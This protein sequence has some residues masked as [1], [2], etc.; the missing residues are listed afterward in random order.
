[1]VD[2]VSY[3]IIVFGLDQISRKDSSENKQNNLSQSDIEGLEL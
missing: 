3:Y 2:V 1:M